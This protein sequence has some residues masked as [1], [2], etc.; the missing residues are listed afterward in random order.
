ARHFHLICPSGAD[1]RLHPGD[2][3]V[4]DDLAAFGLIST[5]PREHALEELNTFRVG[6]GPYLLVLFAVL[7]HREDKEVAT[8]RVVGVPDGCS[9][10]A[11][12]VLPV[13]TSLRAKLVSFHVPT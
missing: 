8:P 3:N 10:Y 1:P 9:P 6:G 12:A 13:A 5:A 7:C 4:E 2:I 11:A